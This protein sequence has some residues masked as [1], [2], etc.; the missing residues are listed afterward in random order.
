M[1]KEDRDNLL[2]HAEGDN[3]SKNAGEV[4]YGAQWY[5]AQ[6]LLDAAAKLDAGHYLPAG[7]PTWAE[8]QRR[9]P[10]FSKVVRAAKA[11]P[12]KRGTRMA[13]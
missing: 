11:L 1:Q 7:F 13:D 10:D 4:F 9:R 6:P 3:R 8:Y 2:G 5:P 12:P